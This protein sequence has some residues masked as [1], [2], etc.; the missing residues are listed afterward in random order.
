M[1][2]RPPFDSLALRQA[3]LGRPNAFSGIDLPEGRL[4]KR[5]SFDLEVLADR[6]AR[7]QLVDVL[8]WFMSELAAHDNALVGRSG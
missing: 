6:T 5:P 8:D 7:L 4:E 2:S 3:L 1:R